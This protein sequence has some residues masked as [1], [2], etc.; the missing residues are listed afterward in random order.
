MTREKFTAEQMIEA[1]RKNNGI[2]A[3]AARSLSCTRQTV[4]NYVNNYS[5]V[6]DAY[7]EANETNIDF[8]ESQLMKKIKSG[9]TTSIIFFLKTKAKHRGYVERIENTGANGA[10]LFSLTDWQEARKKRLEQVEELEEE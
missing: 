5:T 1:I 10:P 4:Q 9:D 3:A 2:L 8:V 7:R 6:K